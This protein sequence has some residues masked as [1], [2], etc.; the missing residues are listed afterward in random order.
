MQQTVTVLNESGLHARPAGMFVK[1]ASKFKSDINIICNESAYNAKSIMN[2]LS[3]GISKGTDIIISSD[4]EDEKE[5]ME[6]LVS[7]VNSRFG[8]E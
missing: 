6:A 3:L 5:A 2:V 7:L 4:G 8:E 1:T